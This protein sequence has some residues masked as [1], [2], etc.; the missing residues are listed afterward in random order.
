M[1]KEHGEYDERDRPEHDADHDGQH[2][3]LVGQPQ[4]GLLVAHGSQPMR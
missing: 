4:R 3:L 1:T 2:F